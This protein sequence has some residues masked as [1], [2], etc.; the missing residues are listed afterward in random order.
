[1]TPLRHAALALLLC[2]LAIVPAGSQPTPIF[3]PSG[4]TV[5]SI[6]TSAPITGGTIT[7]TGTIACATCVTSAAAL[8]SGQLI[9]GAGSQAS[10]VTNLAGD[11]TTSGG[12]TTTI[13]NDAVTYAKMQNVS[14]ASK[15]L[16]R[17][18][19]GSGDPQEITLGS[20]LTMT[21]TTLAASGGTADTVSLVTSDVAHATSNTTLS[22]VTGLTLTIGASA[23]EEWEFRCTLLALSTGTAA[24]WKFGWTVPASATMVWGSLA[25]QGVATGSTPQT[26]TQATT[27]SY[28]GANAT[29]MIGLSG[30]IFGGG[31]G[32]SVQLQF[33]QNASSAQTTTINKGSFCRYRKIVS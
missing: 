31:T 1:M 22:N 6:A 27:L 5:R 2:L 17:G 11:V 8:T 10:A 14:A 16:G 3:P 25:D 7:G 18:D 20:G 32:G 28:G 9:A 4:G 21:G 13:A 24:D 29:I 30:V 23:T 19:S 15:L 33:A 26:G 12:I